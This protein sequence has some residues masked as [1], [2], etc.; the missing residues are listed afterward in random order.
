MR[1]FDIWDCY[2]RYVRLLYPKSIANYVNT[3]LFYIIL[4]NVVYTAYTEWQLLVGNTILF[5]TRYMQIDHTNLISI[6]VERRYLKLDG[7][8][9]HYNLNIQRK[10]TE[11]F[12]L[13]ENI[14]VDVHYIGALC[15]INYYFFW[16]IKTPCLQRQA[17]FKGMYPNDVNVLS[18]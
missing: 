16:D 8:L 15:T 6:Y 4:Q 13:P 12:S 5:R 17:L 3:L 7:C 14:N 1:F 11:R 9:N 10:V 18:V 2:T